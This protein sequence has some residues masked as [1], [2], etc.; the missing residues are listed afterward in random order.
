MHGRRTTSSP[1]ALKGPRREL[2]LLKRLFGRSAAAGVAMIL[3]ALLGASAA[4]AYWPA[5][6]TGSTTAAVAT[7]ARP[8]NVTVPSSSNSNVAVSWTA[9]IG[10]TV[11][12]GYFVTRVTGT[13]AVA[14][15]GS[16]TAAPVTGTSCT[17]PSVPE[18]THRYVVTA[19]HRSWTAVSAT[20][21]NVTVSSINDLRFGIQPA[22][23]VIAGSALP[24]FTVE[25]RTAFGLPFWKSDVPVTI[26]VASNP[27]GG[28][29]SGTVTASTNG[30]GEV[31]FSGLTITRAG[32]YTLIATS[33][34]YAG[35]VSSPFTVTAAAATQLSIT[36]PSSG[37]AS[38][39]AIIGPFVVQR[40]DAYANP[41]TAGSTTMS[42]ASNSTG[43][44][45][46][47]A[48]AGGAS[49]T[50]VTIPAGSASA[51]FFYGDRMAGSWNLTPSATGLS[52]A[53]KP[54]TITP[55]AAS[56]LKFVQQPAFAGQGQNLSPVV[57]H[58][59]DA[60]D[61]LT[62]ST[63]RVVISKVTNPG[64]LSGNPLY[65]DAIG[66]AATFNNLSVSGNVRDCILRVTSEGL[67]A[68]SEPFSVR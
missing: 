36:G 33:P 56:K 57:V 12:T 58:I 19:V 26:G 4:S 30:W 10:P 35:M 43:T 2:V 53:P 28:T 46:F 16:S 51:S 67:T 38:T 32:T 5:S 6:G 22:A 18:G 23:S 49:I 45:V 14:A 13:T 27:S 3:V 62:A 54:V 11:P 60:F 25:L 41:V 68:D 64:S 29:L 8:T 47:A 59:V 55:A 40:R 42:L 52:A 48:T 34:G 7:L 17:D 44:K 21:G 9:S 61:N 1:E 20:S 50:T 15:C 24:A 63:G 39:T 65:A 37:T 31:T 66:G